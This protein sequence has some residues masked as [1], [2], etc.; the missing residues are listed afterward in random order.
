[1]LQQ[2]LVPVPA[3][4]AHAEVLAAA[5]LK[6]VLPMGRFVAASPQTLAAIVDW[7]GAEGALV[8]ELLVPAQGE[9]AQDLGQPLLHMQ[10]PQWTTH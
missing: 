3:A 1:M 6:A 10:L 7:V 2:R 5:A 9:C 4:L 8:D